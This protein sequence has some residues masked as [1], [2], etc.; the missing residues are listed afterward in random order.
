[1]PGTASPSR[2]HPPHHSSTHSVDVLLPTAD[3]VVSTETG[4]SSDMADLLGYALAGND[5][6]D[7]SKPRAHSRLRDVIGAGASSDAD[8]TS[9][10]SASTS[11]STRRRRGPEKPWY[12]RPSPWW[13]LPATAGSAILSSMTVAPKSEVYIRLICA[14]LRPD[15]VL[16]PPSVNFPS[17][18]DPSPSSLTFVTLNENTTAVPR[19]T[20]EC[21]SDPEVARVVAE[22]S[23]AISLITG[24][25]ACLTTAMW[26]QVR[27]VAMINRAEVL[28][29]T[30]FSFRIEL[31]E[32]EC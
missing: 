15:S 18:N 13:I 24:V 11:S 5:R 22:L 19:P 32:P 12:R 10:R 7:R 3:S 17:V 20:P 14:E 25:L 9:Q 31:A 6:G 30:S 21:S 4:V 28:T 1:M 27:A 16:L 23:T 8:T 26:G 2:P 29:A